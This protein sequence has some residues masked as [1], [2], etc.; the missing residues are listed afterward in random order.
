MENAIAIQDQAF[1]SNKKRYDTKAK[2]SNTVAVGDKVWIRTHPKSDATKGQIEKFTA[3]WDGPFR[4]KG[5]VS[6]LTKI[7]DVDGQNK[8]IHTNDI[9][10]YVSG[11]TKTAPVEEPPSEVPVR[12]S[13]RGRVPKRIDKTTWDYH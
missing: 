7:I 1:E 11:D 12:R 10:I 5:S 8:K 4:V 6:D 3:K 9:R 2:G 13:Q